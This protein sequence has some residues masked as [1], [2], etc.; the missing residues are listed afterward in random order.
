M[1]QT[2]PGRRIYLLLFPLLGALVMPFLGLLDLDVAHIE[3]FTTAHILVG[4]IFAAVNITLTQDGEVTRFLDEMIRRISGDSEGTTASDYHRLRSGEFG[5]IFGAFSQETIHEGI[6]TLDQITNDFEF[7]L[8]KMSVI[9]RWQDRWL[10]YL[11]ALIGREPTVYLTI[12]NPPVWDENCL[13]GTDFIHIQAQQQL[14]VKRLFVAP[15]M[16]ELQGPPDKA[17]DVLRILDDYASE[18]AG[19]NHI[20]TRVTLAG[21]PGE[22]HAHFMRGGNYAIAR[23]ERTTICHTVNYAYVP[24]KMPSGYAVSSITFDVNIDLC[25]RREASFERSFRQGVALTEFLKAL[26]ALVEE[27]DERLLGD[28]APAETAVSGFG[29]WIDVTA[30]ATRAWRAVSSLAARAVRTCQVHAWPIGVAAI[31]GGSCCYGVYSLGNSWPTVILAST[32]AAVGG[33]ALGVLVAL[34]GRRPQRFDGI[35]RFA[36]DSATISAFL[37]KARRA[38]GG[39]HGQHFAEIVERCVSS[40]RRDLRE[41][42]RDGRYTLRRRTPADEYRDRWFGLLHDLLTGTE[43]DEMGEFVTVSNLLVWSGSYLGF[44]GSSCPFLNL[45]LSMAGSRVTIRRVF[46]V[47]S[48]DLLAADGSVSEN[49]KRQAIEEWLGTLKRYRDLV[50]ETEGIETKVYEATS[51]DEYNDHFMRAGNF[52]VFRSGSRR[53]CNTV[54]YTTKMNDAYTGYQVESISFSGRPPLIQK[55]LVEFRSRFKQATELDDYVPKL[56]EYLGSLGD[57]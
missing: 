42:I 4:L 34:A 32:T 48:V 3:V 57:S 39:L 46:V 26:R 49:G 35:R 14:P 16:A 13:G 33:G 54:E 19:C 45:Q 43:E 47:P 37:S 11:V 50:G 41:M 1:T 36:E 52:A 15:P 8:A 56:E 6:R 10:R 51:L 12:T 29:T 18:T 44:S 24:R 55:K 30:L 9:Q 2:T 5:E 28:L 40:A 17:E 38:G 7:Q 23:G 20:E 21:N 22:Y 31:L 27:G 53:V 25:R